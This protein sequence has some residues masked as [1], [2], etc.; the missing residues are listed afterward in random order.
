[1]T[2]EELKDFLNSNDL[3]AQSNGMQL[4]SIAEGR[5][6][7]EMDVEQRH[8]NG[9]RVCQGGALFTLADLAFAAV[10][11]ASGRL[12]LGIQSTVSF[13]HPAFEGDHLTAEA[14]E[15]ADHHRTAYV[16]VKV[17]NQDGRVVCAVT[18]IGYRKDRPLTDER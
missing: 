17:R 15:A 7:A 3:F 10:T 2:S 8:L 4:T 1:M 18:G 5:A 14:V 9:G 6:T 16:E 11:N 12:T 13:L